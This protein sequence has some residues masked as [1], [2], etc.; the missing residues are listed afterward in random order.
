MKAHIYLDL[1][2]DVA[3][4]KKNVFDAHSI[5]IIEHNIYIIIT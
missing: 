5:R 2:A 3:I 4:E 1:V